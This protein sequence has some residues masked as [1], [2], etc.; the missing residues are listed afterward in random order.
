MTSQRELATSTLRTYQRA[1][2]VFE[3]WYQENGYAP[4]PADPDHVIQYLQHLSSK[5]IR[6]ATIKIAHA[7]IIQ[8][9]L[10]NGH[11]DEDHHRHI[12]AAMRHLVKAETRPQLSSNPL[13][14]RNLAIIRANACTPKMYTGRYPR[15]EDE[16][17]ARTRGLTDIAIISVMRDGLL[18]TS[19]AKTIRW[20]DLTTTDDGSGKIHLAP[21]TD[22]KY[23][24]F[25][26]RDTVNDLMLIMPDKNTF[27]T[28]AKIFERSIPHINKRIRDAAIAAGL[29]DCYTSESCRIG[30]AKDLNQKFP[31]RKTKLYERYYTDEEAEQGFVARYYGPPAENT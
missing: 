12:K 5:G 3:Q 4:M 23:V 16:Q 18:R 1:F 30:M 21:D 29:G 28:D 17:A 13:T 11:R 19:E 27:D 9:H 15:S 20:G 24:L 10:Q 7:A 31:S 6:A 8:N 2:F 22:P 25:I 14:A 26:S